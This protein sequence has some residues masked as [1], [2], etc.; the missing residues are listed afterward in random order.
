M[1]HGNAYRDAD[2]HSDNQSS[3]EDHV[4]PLFRD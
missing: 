4:L 2:N 1:V 3:T